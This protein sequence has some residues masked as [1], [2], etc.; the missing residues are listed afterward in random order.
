MP[1]KTTLDS[2]RGWAARMAT[3]T[4]STIS[5]SRSWRWNPACPVAQNE[6]AMAHPAWVDTQ[7]VTRSG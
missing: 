4:C 7:T 5:P 3:A 1:M 2:R 6:H